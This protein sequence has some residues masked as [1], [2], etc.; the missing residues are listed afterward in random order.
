MKK[1]KSVLMMVEESLAAG[2]YDGLY[3]CDG[4]CSC[5][6]A[7]GLEPCGD[8]TSECS[9]GYAAPCDGTCDDAPCDGH[10]QLEKP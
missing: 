6:T 8:M 10:V 5:R 9:A 2:G 3:N 4:R 7:D 1:P